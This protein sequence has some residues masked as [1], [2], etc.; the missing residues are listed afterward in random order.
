MT[1]RGFGVREKLSHH[2]WEYT[3]QC[4]TYAYLQRHNEEALK[5]FK[6]LSPYQ[7]FIY[8]TWKSLEALCVPSGNNFDALLKSVF[9]AFK[10]DPLDQ[11]TIEHG[12]LYT[13]GYEDYE[14]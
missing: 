14:E 11:P 1:H 3:A 12:D 9:S 2:F 5:V 10:K 13:S 6:K 7:P 8:Q 4:A